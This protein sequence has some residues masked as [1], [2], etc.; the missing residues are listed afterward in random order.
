M[1]SRDIHLLSSTSRIGSAWRH[2]SSPNLQGMMCTDRNLG[3]CLLHIRVPEEI[4]ILSIHTL[5]AC[6]IVC[7][8]AAR[9][10]A[11]LEY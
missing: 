4:V 1:L 2:A 9:I 7:M 5:N 6:A 3:L 11:A 10:V 8:R